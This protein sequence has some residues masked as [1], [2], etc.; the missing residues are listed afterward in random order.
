LFSTISEIDIILAALISLCIDRGEL[1]THH[2]LFLLV[3]CNADMERFSTSRKGRSDVVYAARLDQSL[4][5]EKFWLTLRDLPELSK[6]FDGQPRTFKVFFCPR[7]LTQS[8]KWTKFIGLT[9]CRER[10]SYV[11]AISSLLPMVHHMQ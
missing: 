1:H 2:F 8:I 3:S 4:L 5:S 6:G 7:T 10:K 9:I 11:T